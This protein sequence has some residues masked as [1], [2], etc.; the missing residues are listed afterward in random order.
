M[1]NFLFRRLFQALIVLFIS[2]IAVFCLLFLAPGG[3]LSDVILAKRQAARYPVQPEDIARLMTQYDLDLPLWESYTRWAF[4]FPNL[5]GRPVRYGVIRGDFGVSWRLSANEPTMAV[6][7][8]A[9]PNTL[10]LTIT[11]TL[12]SLLVGIP[13]GIYSAVH[14]YS[15]V[16]Y[17]VTTGTFFGTAMPVFWLGSMLIL[18]FSFGFKS[19]GLPYLPTGSVTASRSYLEPILGQV[20]AG[21]ASDQLLHLIMP[22]ITLSLLFMAGWSR[23]TRSSMLEVLRQDYVRTARAKGL[24]EQVVINKHALR[25]ALIPLVTIIALQLPFL[26]GGAVITETIFSWQGMGLL[27]INSLFQSDWPVALTFILILSALTIAS[28]VLADILYTVL[29]PRIRIG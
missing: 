22:A 8:R 29:D 28:N 14:Q 27:F 1:T 3:P 16:D 24:L 10:K 23:F 12:L 21:S 25:N 20:A 6:I 18:L 9:L 15:K 7:G 2:S 19:W 17:L 4:G 5:P 11:S 13:V 26:F